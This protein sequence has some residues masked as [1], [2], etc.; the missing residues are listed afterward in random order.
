MI[1][2]NDKNTKGKII[3]AAWDL[4][5]EQG[6]EYT[7]VEE[8]IE[9]SGTSKGSFYHYFEGKD[10]LLGSLSYIFDEEYEKLQKN[11]NENM[12]SLETLL[13]LNRE[14]FKIIEDRIDIE[15]LTRLY[16]TQLITKGEK[17]LL[18][19]KR[20]YYK[21]LKKIVSEGQKKGELTDEITVNEIVRI[22]AMSERALIYDWC[23]CGGEYSLVS[24]A[25]KVMPMYLSGIIK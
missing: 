3:N 9:K 21:L 8:I 25:K 20:L 7:T 13:Y 24:Y 17:H 14:L 10:A 15:L 12:T 5:Y 2:K 4:F 18:D 16:S 23:L 19:N 6:Y 11:L 1:K 22:Y